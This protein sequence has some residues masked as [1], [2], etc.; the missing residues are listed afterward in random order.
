LRTKILAGLAA[1][2]AVL[3]VAAPAFAG[4]GTITPT[5][6]LANGD[7]V[8]V[9]WTGFAAGASVFISQCG[10][11]VTN[12]IFTPSLYC[13]G[14]T[15]VL[16]TGAS[17][18]ATISVFTGIDPDGLPFACGTT[19]DPANQPLRQA[20]G[21]CFIRVTE[22]SNE[23]TTGQFE[24][25]ILFASVAPTTTTTIAPTTVA[26]TTVAPTTVAP[27]TIAPTTTIVDPVV[28]EAPYAVLLPLG[29]LGAIGAGIVL[30][31]RKSIA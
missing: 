27:T 24:S 9:T 12:S 15:Q 20:D 29:A 25:P 28:P 2:A 7:T 19:T 30:S 14:G 10:V 31:R 5:T 21:S 16:G 22:L 3:A 4:T 8:T 26:P 17:G 6:G 13:D 1:S 23:N 18:T 11:S